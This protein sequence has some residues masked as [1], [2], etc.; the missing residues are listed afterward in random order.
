MR[1]IERFLNDDSDPNADTFL[2]CYSGHGHRDG[3]KWCCGDDSYVT[4][5]Q[6]VDLWQV[7][8]LM[9]HCASAAS[10]L[11]FLKR[12]GACQDGH[13]LILYVDSC[14]SGY[15][16]VKAQQRRLPNVIVQTACSDTE[17]SID[18][19]FTKAFVDYQNKP[20]APPTSTQLLSRT[21]F[22]YVP[23]S[24]SDAVIYQAT[25]EGRAN[26]KSPYLHLLSFGNELRPSGGSAAGSSR[27]M[28]TVTT[29]GA[30]AL[31][32]IML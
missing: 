29:S 10:S 21:P 8:L 32:A 15:W 25:R 6:V 12:S 31:A 22:V 23:W 7:C 30:P 11:T 20:G 9:T 19:V 13:R 2:L 5:E 28:V 1:R 16:A 27:S 17:T 4:F 26:R 3:G 18:G 14:F 24:Q